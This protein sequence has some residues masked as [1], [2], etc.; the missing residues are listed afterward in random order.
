MAQQYDVAVK[1]LSGSRPMDF[2]QFAL[3]AVPLSV[4]VIVLQPSSRISDRWQMDGAGR[5]VLQCQFQVV[6]LWEL[7]REHVIAQEL[8]AV[9]L[10]PGT[11]TVTARPSGCRHRWC[12]P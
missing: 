6:R 11:T 8:P 9:R 12:V 1:L 4:E 5:T 3:G 10:G 2:V 7:P